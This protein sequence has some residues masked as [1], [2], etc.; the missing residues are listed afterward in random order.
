MRYHGTIS[1]ETQGG[2]QLTSEDGVH[3]NTL[4]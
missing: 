2:I 1:Q 4:P 3:P